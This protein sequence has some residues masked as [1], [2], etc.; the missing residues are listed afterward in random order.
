MADETGSETESE[1]EYT[2]EE[3]TGM[4]GEAGSDP[5]GFGNYDLSG[6]AVHAGGGQSP[7]LGA[8]AYTQGGDIP[9]VGGEAAL[10]HEAWHVVQQGHAGE[11]EAPEAETEAGTEAEPAE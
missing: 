8:L 3:D 2:P 1:T 5:S 6:I 9:G 4:E 7:E 11:D 10:A